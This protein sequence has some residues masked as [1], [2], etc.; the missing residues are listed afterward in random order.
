MTTG[1]RTIGITEFFRNTWKGVVI[2]IGILTWSLM[3]AAPQM[4][5]MTKLSIMPFLL[6]VYWPE[7]LLGLI[8][9]VVTIAASLQ[10][11]TIFDTFAYLT[12]SLRPKSIRELGYFDTITRLLAIGFAV[13]ILGAAAKAV[14]SKFDQMVRSEHEFASTSL[15]SWFRND[16]L[17]LAV[18]HINT[19]D[20]DVA[21]KILA[22][23]ENEFRSTEEGDIAK[24]AHNWIQTIS[25]ES[26]AGLQWVSERIAVAGVSRADILMQGALLDALP[27]S[28]V[29]ESRVDVVDGTTQIDAYRDRL[30]Y[31]RRTCLESGAHALS[32]RDV[33]M[34]ASALGFARSPELLFG[35]TEHEARRAALCE[36]VQAMTEGELLKASQAAFSISGASNRHDWRINLDDA[37]YHTSG[38]IVMHGLAQ[39]IDLPASK[40]FGSRPLTRLLGSRPKALEIRSQSFPGTET[41]F[42]TVFGNIVNR[43]IDW[44]PY[45]P[46]SYIERQDLS[47]GEYSQIVSSQ[48]GSALIVCSGTI[49]GKSAYGLEFSYV[50]NGRVTASDSRRCGQNR[51]GQLQDGIGENL[52]TVTIAFLQMLD[53]GKL[54]LAPGLD[55]AKTRSLLCRILVRDGGREPEGLRDF[56]FRYC[57]IQAITKKWPAARTEKRGS[58]Q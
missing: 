23:Q 33:G 41:R 51:L 9:I 46:I 25:K 30:Q 14:L 42:L 27:K 57:P 39:G 5:F 32:A 43:T 7:L 26:A 58:R 29:N 4:G 24:S 55:P 36:I 10:K 37:P 34:A 12:N 44:R 20:Y 40:L 45:I 16:L 31:V 56:A 6:R 38:W 21:L 53:S 1:M 3:S 52:L 49:D 28:S 35:T 48:G 50:D 17:K 13:I 15:L 19:G 22:A 8:A 54:Q 2:V 11:R 18:T 47:N